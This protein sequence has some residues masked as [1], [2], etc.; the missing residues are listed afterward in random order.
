MPRRA[1]YLRYV[2]TARERAA[3][4]LLETFDSPFLRALTEPSRL[5]LVRQLLIHGRSDVATLA[6][7]VPQERSVV[8][9]HLKVLVDAGIA[10]VVRDGKRRVYEL[11]SQGLVASVEAIA[12]RV[13][14]AAPA[15]CPPTKTPSSR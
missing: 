8:S 4:T 6:T 5:E 10:T 12:M 9:R 1:R 15:C 3:N 7:R 2:T 14:S 13:R 11:D